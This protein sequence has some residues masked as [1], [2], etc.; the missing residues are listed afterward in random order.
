MKN[1][2]LPLNRQFPLSHSLR[3]AQR[4]LDF[5]TVHTDFIAEHLIFTIQV[6]LVDDKRL[7]VYRMLP[8][9]FRAVN[10]SIYHFLL[11]S[12]TYIISNPARVIYTY[13]DSLDNCRA[14]T[15][16][17]YFCTIPN[18]Q[19]TPSCEIQLLAEIEAHCT[20]SSTAIQPLI[21]VNLGPNQWLFVLHNTERLTI[22]YQNGST[23][24]YT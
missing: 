23:S 20:L 17:E 24:T 9:P 13:L 11:P 10:S 14:I 7:Q 4:Y 15:Q 1:T 22:D 8:F 18:Y 12:H 3:D 6:P 16:E 2:K 19:R 21:W 5:S